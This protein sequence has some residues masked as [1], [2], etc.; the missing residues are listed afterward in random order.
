MQCATCHVYVDPRCADPLAPLSELEDEMLD[1]AAADRR[2]ESRLSCQ[3]R[4]GPESDLHLR[5]PDRQL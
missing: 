3:I 2:P 1:G 5:L 4:I